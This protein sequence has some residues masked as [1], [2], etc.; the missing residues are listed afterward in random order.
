MK[1]MEGTERKNLSVFLMIFPRARDIMKNG[2]SSDGNWRRHD[3]NFVSDVSK[4][5]F[6]VNHGNLMNNNIFW[7]DRSD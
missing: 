1:I 2:K 3:G 7:L 4:T 5:D 6:I